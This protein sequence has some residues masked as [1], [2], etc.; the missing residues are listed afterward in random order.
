LNGQKE[1]EKLKAKRA[2][3]EAESL[4]LKE[5]QK[6]LEY[7]VKILEETV[8]IQELKQNNKIAKDAIAKLEIKLN[9]LEEKLEPKSNM[10]AGRSLSNTMQVPDDGVEMREAPET[11]AAEG[12]LEGCEEEVVT[13]T[14]VNDEDLV[15]TQR[16]KIDGQQGKKKRRFF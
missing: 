3:L 11:D 12:T 2:E 14:A 7:N 4:N 9:K 13:I 10:H 6:Q 16:A 5:E 15:V 8:R 1:L